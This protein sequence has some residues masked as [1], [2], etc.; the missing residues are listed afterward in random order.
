MIRMN[1]HD[2]ER[3]LCLMYGGAMK[4]DRQGNL[5]EIER[6]A[7]FMAIMAI[8]KRTK[9][10]FA[11][12]EGRLFKRWICPSCFRSVSSE[13]HFCPECGQ[14]YILPPK[15]KKRIVICDEWDCPNKKT[16]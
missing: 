3:V 11:E 1:I 7:V 13:G 15:K 5:S 8:Q 9:P 16:N 6:E 2:A 12:V 10:R 14:A 4:G